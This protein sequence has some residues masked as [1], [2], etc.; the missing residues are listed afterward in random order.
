MT[1]NDEWK[2][3]LMAK[4]DTTTHKFIQTFLKKGAVHQTYMART[5]V[6]RAIFDVDTLDIG[7]IMDCRSD[8]KNI[9][10]TY[11]SKYVPSAIK[12]QKCECNEATSESIAI[13]DIDLG[14]FAKVR[15]DFKLATNEIICDTCG[16]T[17]TSEYEFSE[18]IFVDPKSTLGKTVE[19][20]K[21]PPVIV[22]NDVSYILAAFIESKGGPPDEYYITNV[23]KPNKRWYAMDGVT[24][25]MESRKLDGKELNMHLIIYTLPTLVY[26]KKMLRVDQQATTFPV[27]QNFH[28]IIFG[29]R[30]TTVNEACGFD[31]LLHA[32]S[33]IFQKKPE[34]FADQKK[35]T[36]M[37]LVK[38]YVDRE[39]DAVYQMRV[40]LLIDKFKSK[41]HKNNVT[42]NCRDNI[43]DMV[44]FFCAGK[45]SSI[46]WQPGCSC[47][48]AMNMSRGVVGINYEKHATLGFGNICD[49]ICIPNP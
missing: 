33:Q 4:F 1:E 13:L 22:V 11:F 9:V 31:C 18:I 39:M 49:S 47:E 6:L 15:S 26:D 23:V 16:S 37:Q 30:R 45:L 46:I 25:T 36:L 20:S 14:L 48:Q 44:E 41:E 28:T 35:M 34:L 17:Q 40:C 29:G 42:I 12:K 38:A 3:L 8:V 5:Q 2:E 27:I 7:R 19:F 24:C 32:I 43:K 10:Q 21:I